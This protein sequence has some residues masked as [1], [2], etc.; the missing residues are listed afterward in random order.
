MNRPELIRGERPTARPD[1][2]SLVRP[3]TARTLRF[4]AWFV[5]ARWRVDDVAWLFDLDA[6]ELGEALARAA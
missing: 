1:T 6:Q 2:V 3:V 4:A 5:A